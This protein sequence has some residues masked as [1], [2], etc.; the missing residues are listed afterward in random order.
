MDESWLSKRR[1]T[2]EQTH[3]IRDE[4]VR[5][6]QNVQFRTSENNDQ[7]HIEVLRSRDGKKTIDDVKAV[8]EAAKA[9]LGYEPTEHEIQVSGTY[10][11][12][13]SKPKTR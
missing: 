2:Q 8:R 10:A 5:R 11:L 4:L 12:G 13:E 9:V 6:G 1:L 7:W 3:L